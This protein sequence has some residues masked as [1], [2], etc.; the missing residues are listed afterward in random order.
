LARLAHAYFA[1]WNYGLVP[2]LPEID[3]GFRT[4]KEQTGF[5]P[6]LWSRFLGKY[7]K[8]R[9]N[10]RIRP[11]FSFRLFSGLVH[12]SANCCLDCSAR[13]RSLEEK[14]VIGNRRICQF[15][16]VCCYGTP[17]VANKVDYFQIT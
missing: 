12:L 15:F 2:L 7:F 8:I 3:H 9:I 10:I 6:S 5:F 13:F 4:P 14:T 16:S 11:S 1:H 17:V